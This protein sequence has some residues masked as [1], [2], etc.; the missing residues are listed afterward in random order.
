MWE[1]GLFEEVMC[2]TKESTDAIHAPIQF[3]QLYHNCVLRHRILLSLGFW[4]LHFC[5]VLTPSLWNADSEWCILHF[6]FFFL[7]QQVRIRWN[8]HSA[9]TNKH[10]VPQGKPHLSLFNRWYPLETQQ[11]TV[12]PHIWSLNLWIQLWQSKM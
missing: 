11:P 8:S 6:L 2:H 12:L 4:T 9:V 5:C 1:F 3:S 10:Q 7:E